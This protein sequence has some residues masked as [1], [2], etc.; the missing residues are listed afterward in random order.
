[1]FVLNDINLYMFHWK[2]L[3]ILWFVRLWIQNWAKWPVG[4][5]VAKVMVKA[6]G[7]AVA[8]AI[9]AAT[10]GV[11]GK[12]V[13]FPDDLVAAAAVVAVW[14]EVEEQEE[15]VIKMEEVDYTPF[16]PLL[17]MFTA[18]VCSRILNLNQLVIT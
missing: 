10:S 7:A 9:E 14:T 15:V 11:A 5:E 6:V 1:M 3:K 17:K 4:Q 12:T 2:R 18:F 16:H 8:V 13:V